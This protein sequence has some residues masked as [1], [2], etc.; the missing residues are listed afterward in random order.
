M[1]FIIE[2][3]LYLETVNVPK[4]AQTKPAEVATNHLLIVDCSGSMWGEL[5]K[6]REHIKTKIPKLMREGD[7]LSL[8][9]FSGR[10][11][12]WRILTTESV[13]GPRDLT[14]VNRAVDRWL[15]P[16]GMTGFK[17][18]IEDATKL[19]AEVAKK[20][21][22]RPFN[23]MF[24]SDGYENQWPKDSVLSAIE[25]MGG[26][27]AAATVVSYGNYADLNFLTKM[28][29]RWGGT[30]IQSESFSKFEP[31]LE[32]VV[33]KKVVGGKKVEL[34]IQSDVIGGVVF[35]FDGDEI[36]TFGIDTGVVGAAGAA[37]DVCSMHLASSVSVPPSVEQVFF[38]SPAGPGRESLKGFFSRSAVGALAVSSVASA[39]Y[40]A[41]SVFATRMRPD[42]VLPLLAATGDKRLIT[43]FSTLFGRQ[44]YAEFQEVT[45]KAAVDNGRRWLDGF[46]QSAVPRDDAF[47]IVEL[48]ELL[49]SD[50]RN[51]LLL[52]H[53]SFKYN[54]IGRARVDANA[55]FTDAEQAEIDALTEELSKVKKSVAK[56]KEIKAKL[57]AL[58]N[59][60]E[61][62]EFVEKKPADGYDLD[63]IV[64]S[65]DRAN[66]SLRVHKFG[67]VDLSSRL[68]FGGDKLG[69]VPTTFATH[70]YRN[71]AILKDGIVNVEKL[72]V[73]LDKSN[74]SQLVR[75]V[76]AGRLS[77]RAFSVAEPSNGGPSVAL[78]IN[79]REIPVINRQMVK[80]LSAKQLFSTE[81]ELLKARARQKVYNSFLKELFPGPKSEAYAALY[82]KEAA[83]W[84][85]AQGLTDGGFSPKSLVGDATDVYMAKKFEVKIKGYS[86]IPSLNDWRKQKE[87]GKFNGPGALMTATVG[88]VEH[89]VTL[90]GND[91]GGAIKTRLEKYAKE[92][93]A[94]V[95]RLLREQAQMKFAVIVGQTWFKEF[96]SLEESTMTLVMD[97]NQLEFTASLREVEE[98]I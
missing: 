82:G 1:S 12:F 98:K 86:T 56:T 77:E 46:D 74:A 23:V 2:K 37:A 92:E 81:W 34:V 16:T 57:D 60:P 24:L 38:L 11:E 43:M 25:K 6:V 35:A 42:V 61:P 27:V 17:E 64:M 63:A 93:T 72:P 22:K 87:K 95:R 33:Q 54:R 94:E 10:G 4:S 53:P 7:S 65:E 9:G 36:V 8:I 79:L 59:K 29:E 80:E 88:V 85:A 45:A 51:R 39:T 62:L 48:I 15:K 28:A 26:T 75:A 78:T 5:E 69:S 84:L 91:S 32:A 83:D 49:Q 44:K 41:I 52:D 58:T 31:V 14:T 13:D 21:D 50:D 68:P 47:S 96:S 20:G 97:G 19:M 67:T 66:I 40:A 3:G 55:R 76:E 89:L 30:M 71:Y 70:T 18:P 90:G 73:L